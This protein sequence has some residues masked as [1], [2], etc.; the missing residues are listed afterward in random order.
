MLYY[1]CP[2]EPCLSHVVPTVN[3]L[4]HSECRMSVLSSVLAFLKSVVVL[5]VNVCGD[6]NR[7]GYHRLIFEYLV[8]E[9]S[10]TA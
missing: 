8:M 4:V 6:L 2:E 5:Y 3:G 9:G 1:G 10:G 7:D